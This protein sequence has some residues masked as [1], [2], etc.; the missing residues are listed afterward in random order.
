MNPQIV[1]L[2]Q[3]AAIADARGQTQ[4]QAVMEARSITM[5]ADP[6]GLTQA[7]MIQVILLREGVEESSEGQS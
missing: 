4:T 2:I 6:R 3:T 1:T 7:S 5:A